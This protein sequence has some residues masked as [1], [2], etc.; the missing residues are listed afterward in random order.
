MTRK[1]ILTAVREG[2]PL[3]YKS[4]WR[5]LW[6]DFKPTDFAEELIKYCYEFRLRPH[7]VSSDQSTSSAG[8]TH[9]SLNGGTTASRIR[10]YMAEDVPGHPYAA[11]A[12]RPLSPGWGIAA[13]TRHPAFG[14]EAISLS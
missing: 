12:S 8:D 6:L 7:D 4:K 10:A 9:A 13:Y 1:Q 5:D 14:R 2:T 3:Q 11:K